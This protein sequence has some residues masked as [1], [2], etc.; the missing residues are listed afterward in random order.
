MDLDAEWSDSEMDDVC[1]EIPDRM[2]LLVFLIDVSGSMDGTTIGSVN[3]IM[4]EL[5]ED[6]GK[7][8]SHKC[9]AVAAFGEDVAW[10]GDKPQEPEQFGGWTRLHAT[11][12]SNMGKVF[13]ELADRLSRKDWCQEGTNGIEGVFVMFSDGLAT[14]KYETGLEELKKN[15]VFQQGTRLAVNFSEIYDGNVLLDFAG[16]KENVLNM[17]INEIS[18]TEKRILDAVTG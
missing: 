13:S 3:S 18:K 7:D 1:G 5:V 4:E 9:I 8:K 14:D 11:N 16:K 17:K 12:F 15:P 10:N 2:K 6:M